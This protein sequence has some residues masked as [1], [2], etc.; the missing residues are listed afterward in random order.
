MIGCLAQGEKRMAQTGSSILRHLLQ[1]DE[2]DLIR[3]SQIAFPGLPSLLAISVP[4]A[5]STRPSFFE[6][7]EPSSLSHKRKAGMRFQ[8]TREGSF[9]FWAKP[10]NR[11][12]LGLEFILL[13]LV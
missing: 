8:P 9:V 1:A 5:G 6:N 10:L 4:I 3:A 2:G 12:F 11:L 13:V 7:R